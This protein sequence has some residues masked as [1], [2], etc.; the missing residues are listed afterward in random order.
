MENRVV[1]VAERSWMVL[2]PQFGPVYLVHLG[3]TVD[4]V[5]GETLIL[6]QVKRWHLDRTKWETVAK[7]DTYQEVLAWLEVDEQRARDAAEAEARNYWN[8]PPRAQNGS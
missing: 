2:T 1:H 7:V 6:Y 3:P 8:N 4:Q 5:T